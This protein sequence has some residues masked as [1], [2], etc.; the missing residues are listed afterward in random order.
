MEPSYD[1]NCGSGL[2]TIRPFFIPG[3]IVVDTSGN[4]VCGYVVDPEGN[5]I[6]GATVELW[7]DFP[8]G[9]VQMTQTASGNGVFAFAD[10]TTIPFDL[11]AYQNGY[12]PGKVENINFA[13]SGIM[14]VLTPYEAVTPTN[15]WVNFYCGTNTYQGCSATGWFCY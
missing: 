6:P 15:E 12:Y 11:Y 1:R 4:Y 5:P 7:N 13:Q 8:G 14:I 3:G 2:E 9:A 10:F